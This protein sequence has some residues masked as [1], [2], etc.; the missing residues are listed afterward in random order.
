MP[1][2]VRSND[3][4]LAE[5]ARTVKQALLAGGR[6]LKRGYTAKRRVFFKSLTSPV[7]H[8]DMRSERAIIGLIRKRFPSHGF[9]AEESSYLNEV[10]RATRR[11]LA[12]GLGVAEGASARDAVKSGYRWI[13][14]PL[15]GTV[16]FL[17]GIPQSCVS[18]AVE[19][20]GTVL[21]GGVYDPH[22]DELFLA[23]RG[24]GA[25]MNG[26]RIHVSQRAP[27]Q[28]SLLMTGFPYDHRRRAAY[29]L[30]FLLPFLQKSMD[31]R[32][33]GAA[34]LDLSWVACGRIEGYWEFHLNPW[35]VAAGLLLVQEAGGKV[36]DFSGVPM[37]IDQPRETLA[38]NGR[39]HAEMLQV[40]KATKSRI[41]RSHPR[42]RK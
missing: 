26:R 9:L 24:G 8:I 12:A 16:N 20:E 41:R 13:I 17:H 10:T 34:A 40:L 33:F 28:R 42:K 5:L 1:P 35:D 7:T 2:R 18:I 21:A 6:I 19:K 25:T 27:L 30:T 14:D 39:V 23:Q 4:T 37:D 11:R 3:P 36:T 29:Y 38:S 32:R 31:L 15:D 22:R